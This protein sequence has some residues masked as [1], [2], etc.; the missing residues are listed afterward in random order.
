MDSR[1][2]DASKQI[3]KDLKS[4]YLERF[5][6]T[7]LL[8]QKVVENL[9]VKG[10]RDVAT[11]VNKAVRIMG[12]SVK[13]P[14][15]MKKILD[16]FGLMEHSI[17]LF[18]DTIEKRTVQSFRSAFEHVDYD[19]SAGNSLLGS[20]V[21][22]ICKRHQPDT[23]IEVRGIDELEKLLEIKVNEWLRLGD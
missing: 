10:R 2:F 22:T 1:K 6:G 15:L 17:N 19:L 4:Q 18:V 13:P 16:K 9:M 11:E 3:Y 7:H 23:K 5:F 20:K 14:L 21:F 12:N 8:T